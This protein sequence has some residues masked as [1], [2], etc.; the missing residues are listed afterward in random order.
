MQNNYPDGGSGV[1]TRLKSKGV[2]CL[3]GSESFPEEER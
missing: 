3:G 2:H 1:G